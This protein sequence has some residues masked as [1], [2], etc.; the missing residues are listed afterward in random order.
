MM[1]AIAFSDHDV[2]VEVRERAAP[3][4]RL[5]RYTGAAFS[6]PPEAYRNGRFDPPPGAKSD[7]AVL[8]AADSIGAAAMETR[9]LRVSTDDEYSYAEAQA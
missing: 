7:F 1:P 6:E 2:Q 8:Y 3:L 9:V 4:V 5:F